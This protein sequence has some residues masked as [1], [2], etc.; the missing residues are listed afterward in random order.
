M[1][2]TDPSPRA[3]PIIDVHT[4]P[5]YRLQG[6]TRPEAARLVALGRSLGIVRMVCLGD[7]LRHGAAPTEP[8]VA[9]I[10]D[11]SARVRSFFP[12]YFTCFCFLN[13]TLGERAVAREVER[14]VTRH[15]FAG[16]KLEICNNAREEVHM[17]AVM[18]AAARWRIPV[19]QHTWN[20]THIRRRRLHSEPADTA[21]LARRHPE[22]QVIMAHLTGCE[23]RGVLEVKRLPN[24]VLDTSG[25]PPVDGLLEYAVEQL[26]ADRVLYGSDLPGRSPAVAIGRVLGSRLTAAEKRKVLHDNA[27]R[28]LGLGPA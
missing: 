4:H 12:D 21:L 15:G 19:L 20:M 13:P 28:L 14:C 11:D 23:T 5:V 17:R 1:A 2:A 16:I 22:V 18:E 8:Q 9:A 7:V 26:G 10:N 3:G 24:V 6:R 25:G 27:A